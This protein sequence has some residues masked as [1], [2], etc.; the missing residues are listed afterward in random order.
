M[1]LIGLPLAQNHQ[2]PAN[3]AF[4]N[5]D[6][7]YEQPPIVRPCRDTKAKHRSIY[8]KLFH[9]YGAIFCLC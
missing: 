2:L 1:L 5:D 3:P 4:E 8:S 9:Y 7:I 6:V